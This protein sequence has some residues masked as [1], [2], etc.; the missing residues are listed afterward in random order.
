MDFTG[1]GTDSSMSYASAVS[2]WE[3]TDEAPTSDVSGS[4]RF[5]V[6]IK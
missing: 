3:A 4:L 2:G 1:A 6:Q 5:H